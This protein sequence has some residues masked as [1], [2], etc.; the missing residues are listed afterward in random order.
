[1]T[2]REDSA[3]L[4]GGRTK[5]LVQ[6]AE[7]D[8]QTVSE[9]LNQLP[10]TRQYVSNVLNELADEGLLEKEYSIEDGRKKQYTVT[11]EGQALLDV[12]DGI[13]AGA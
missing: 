7:R 10:F 3:L 1:M 4:K 2:S 6:A 5:V 9:I 12:L 13:Y 8:S 11:E